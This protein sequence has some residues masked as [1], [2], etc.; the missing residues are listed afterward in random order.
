MNKTKV[1]EK[2]LQWIAQS[3]VSGK[4]VIEYQDAK[5]GKIMGNC[6]I[7]YVNSPASA[8]HINTTI[9]IDVKDF[10][11][12]LTLTGTSIY[13]THKWFRRSGSDAPWDVREDD[14][15]EVRK[16]LQKLVGAFTLYMSQK[17][18]DNW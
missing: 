3:F 6:S 5:S 2:S 17:S 14:I 1:F 8:W 11:A 16:E 4:S 10:K 12:R 18:D 15:P 9:A 7:P 13:S